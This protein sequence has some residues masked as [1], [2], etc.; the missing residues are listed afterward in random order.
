MTALA[1]NRL[2]TNGVAPFPNIFGK[3]AA[4]VHIYAG[5]LIACVAGYWQPATVAPGL[6]LAVA[7]NEFD[8]SGGLAT[9]TSP[10]EVEFIKPKRLVLMVN[11]AGSPITQAEIGGEGWVLDDQTVG[12][13]G[14]IGTHTKVIPWAF[15]NA[16]LTSSTT[17][18]WVEVL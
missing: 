15:Y 3:V 7:M 14:A 13:T 8:N 2:N 5:A 1:A 4:G 11:D 16:N 10:L 12:A 6:Q 17:K 9:T 18:V